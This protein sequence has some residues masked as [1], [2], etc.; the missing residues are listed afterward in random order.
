MQDRADGCGF[1]Q[2][3]FTCL[4]FRQKVSVS[5]EQFVNLLD[6]E[7]DIRNDLLRQF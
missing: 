3:G 7:F 6:F 5:F 1:N 2:V 4:R